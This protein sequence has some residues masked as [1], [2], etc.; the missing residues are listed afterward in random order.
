MTA[1]D[2]AKNFWQYYNEA[3]PVNVM[4]VGETSCDKNYRVERPMSH[5]IA[6]E[7]NEQGTG[8]LLINEKTYCTTANSAVVLTKNSNHIYFT[9]E[10]D[11]QKKKW[12]VFDGEAMD[13]L[14][15]KYLP[16]DKYYF[17]NC[18]LS[19][20]FLEIQK[21]ITA[22]EKNY[23]QMVDAISVI[24][25]RMIIEMK[26]SGQKSNL[27]LAEKIRRT[28]DRHV[29][30]KLDLDK[31]AKE[32]N[33]SKNYIIRIF[34]EEYDLTPYRYFEDLKLHVAKMYLANTAFTIREISEMLS[35]TDTHYFSKMFKKETGK[36]PSAF[37]KNSLDDDK[38]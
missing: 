20:Y 30:E 16:K 37:R 21:A 29:E 18:N 3:L 22:Y 15:K 14:I 27:S 2:V 35:F 36:T 23:C 7:Y 6:I 19:F 32:L 9:D 38:I 24:I 10:A 4:V 26:N 5:I 12:I 8:S 33:Y 34:R 28:L 17:E 11:L 1:G 13:F 25:Y 31:V